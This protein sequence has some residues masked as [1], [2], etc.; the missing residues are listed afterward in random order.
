MSLAILSALFV[1]A[2]DPSPVALL[3]V[4]NGPNTAPQ[5]AAAEAELAAAARWRPALRVLPTETNARAI[6]C[7]GDVDCLAEALDSSAI[8]FA[9]L[10]IVNT[11]VEPPLSAL[12]A[13]DV[14]KRKFAASETTNA[15][16]RVARIL[17]TLGFAEAGRLTIVHDAADAELLVEP[18]PLERISPNHYWLAPG[19]YQ[20]TLSAGGRRTSTLTTI[21]KA[22][23]TTVNLT[24]GAQSSLLDSP[25][26]W[27][28][29]G[30][31]VLA[32]SG[33]IIFAVT[34]GPDEVCLGPPMSCP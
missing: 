28:G 24:L 6:R 20:L 34:R 15:P 29:V 7:G 22:R 3:P 17:D 10:L 19:N 13:F 25:W 26:F 30:A 12:R 32:V 8:S 11:E 21:E 16:D 9:L 27:T 14:A 2:L 33:A 4:L 5:L 23:E 31:G 1:A 18:A